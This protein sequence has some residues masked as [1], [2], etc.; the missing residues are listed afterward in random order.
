[1]LLC[2]PFPVPKSLLNFTHLKS[3]LE[4]QCSERG[5]NFDVC[6]ALHCRDSLFGMDAGRDLLDIC[7]PPTP[8]EILVPCT[9]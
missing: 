4:L 7:P 1:M 3:F 8:E 2:T 5:R 6:T 9:K